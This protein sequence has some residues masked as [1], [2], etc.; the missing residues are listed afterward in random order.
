[1]EGKLVRVWLNYHL[2]LSSNVES[3]YRWL[4]KNNAEETGIGSA[5]MLTY[6]DGVQDLHERIQ[7]DLLDEGVEI[8]GRLYL[9]CPD[10]EH[11][12]KYV[13]KFVYGARR[14]S[15]WDEYKKSASTIDE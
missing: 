4:G 2:N 13:G 7:Q 15:N 14:P 5:T 6:W 11:P 9:I 1:M 3:F 8:S 10:P 12:E